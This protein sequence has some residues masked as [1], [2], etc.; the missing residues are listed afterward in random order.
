MGSYLPLL[1]IEV[2]HN[3][4][5]K[6]SCLALEFVLTPGTDKVMENAGMLRRN[7]MNGIHIFYDKN[8]SDSLKLYATDLIN[9]LRLEFKVFS[10]DPFFENYTEPSVHQEGSILY[11]DNQRAKIDR[12]GR[13][14]LHD[15]EYVSETDFEELNS[16]LFEDILNKKDRLIRPV[17][18]VSVSISDKD[19]NLS[20]DQLEATAKSYYLNFRARQTFWK[21]YLLGGMARKDLYIADLKNEEEFESTGEESLSDS[22]IAL[23][24]RSKTTIPL[25]EKSDC[26]FQLREGGVGNGKVLINRLPVAS[27]TQINREVIEGKEAFVS[28]M[29][30]NC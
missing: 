8:R 26:R 15:E 16:S 12:T 9:P 1:N 20:S 18:I 27:A 23:T 7:T 28:E 24:F 22:R 19:V 21:Y 29:F 6:G 14:R 2:E 4:F 17:S 11:F 3:F 10:R 5:S 13:F 25:Q 30:I